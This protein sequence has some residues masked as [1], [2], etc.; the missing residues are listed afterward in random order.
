MDTILL[1]DENEERTINYTVN[2]DDDQLEM[3]KMAGGLVFVVIV[4]LVCCISC[5]GS[6]RIAPAREDAAKADMAALKAEE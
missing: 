2:K 5:S 6:M 3:M 1:D 4:F